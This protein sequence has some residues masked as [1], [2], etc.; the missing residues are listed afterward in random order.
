MSSQDASTYYTVLHPEQFKTDWAAFY[1][2]ADATTADT[3]KQVRHQ[4]DF[5][6]GQDVRQRLDLYYPDAHTSGVPVFLFLHGGAFREG[7]RAQYGFV[8]RPFVR[9][10]IITAV[11]SYRLTGDGFRY[12]DQRDDA[13]LA[14]H[15]LYGNIGRYGGDPQHI[16]VGGHSCGAIMAADL[17]VNRAWLERAEAPKHLLRGLIGISAPY[18]LRTPGDPLSG[19]VFWSRYVP[20]QEMRTRASP[21]LHVAD[22]VPDALLAAGSTEN[23]GYDDYVASSK[24]FVAKL[25]T[26]GARA[27][28]LSIEGAAHQDTVL[29]LGDEHSELTQLAIQMISPARAP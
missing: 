1:R 13:R 28:Y 27:R 3:R 26:A 29:A 21:L 25:T 4:L 16:W 15:W 2:Q 12:P 19:K 18:D 11:A 5:Q 17:C 8:A 10:R 9:H 6:Y 23:E 14:L 22:P 7:D 24:E 20:T